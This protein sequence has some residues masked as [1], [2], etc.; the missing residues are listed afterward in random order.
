MKSNSGSYR[1]F[2]NAFSE[3]RQFSPLKCEEELTLHF[4][5]K[6]LF[7]RHV[8]LPHAELNPLVYDAVNQFTQ[9]YRGERLT[10]T[11]LG[12]SIS[13]PLQQTIR[14]VF[15]T[16]YE[17]EYRK[18]SMYL[19]RRYSRIVL[20]LIISLFA[21][22]VGGFLNTRLDRDTFF[23]TALTN[24]GIF[25]LWQIGTTHFERKAVSAER[26]RILRARDAEIRFQ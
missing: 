3:K 16:H 1:Q 11:I 17:E 7:D 18:A 24:L 22:Y 15:Y 26:K 6:E 2:F 12:D 10:V 21:Y 14:E 5:K 23:F 20:L 9:R 19:Y 8:L 13:E 25:C 4:S